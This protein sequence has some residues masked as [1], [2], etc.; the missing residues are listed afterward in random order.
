[1]PCLRLALSTRPFER[2]GHRSRDAERGGY[3][4]MLS[5]TKFERSDRRRARSPVTCWI[6][7]ALRALDLLPVKL[8]GGAELARAARV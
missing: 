7:R 1:M 8:R 4:V 5:L 6:R 2:A 3:D